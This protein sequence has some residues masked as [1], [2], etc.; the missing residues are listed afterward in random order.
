MISVYLY[1][2]LSFIGSPYYYSHWSFHL[3]TSMNEWFIRLCLMVHWFISSSWLLHCWLSGIVGIITYN[4]SVNHVNLF[5]ILLILTSIHRISYIHSIDVLDPHSN[6][7]H[8]HLNNYIYGRSIYPLF[9]LILVPSIVRI[10]V[11]SC[12]F[13]SLCIS[14]CLGLSLRYWLIS[15]SILI[16]GCCLLFRLIR[17]SLLILYI[18]D[19]YVCAVMLSDPQHMTVYR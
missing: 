2:Y 5:I 4:E 19:H 11:G 9:I 15:L 14:L 12:W 6:L 1:S 17:H 18:S 8:Y 3:I 13:L 16:N 10:R 7:I